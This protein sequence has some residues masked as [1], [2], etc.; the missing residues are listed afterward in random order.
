MIILAVAF[1][2][3]NDDNISTKDLYSMEVQNVPIELQ[4]D[5]PSTP[6]IQ[7]EPLGQSTIHSAI[8][9]SQATQPAPE[10]APLPPPFVPA[11]TPSQQQ[12][13]TTQPPLRLSRRKYLLFGLVIV[14]LFVIGFGG[15][16]VYSRFFKYKQIPTLDQRRFYQAT[17]SALDP[18]VHSDMQAIDAVK[19]AYPDLKDFGNTNNRLSPRTFIWSLQ[20]KTGWKVRFNRGYGKCNNDTCERDQWY[21]FTVD[22]DGKVTKVGE[23]EII[24]KPDG[25]EQINGIRVPN[26]LKEDTLSP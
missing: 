7:A 10:A 26:F 2:I 13:Q 5:A 25:S 14:I 18:S 17:F 24:Q 21:Y 3:G 23:V 20:T 11:P 1:Y 6:S 19:K 12:P 16:W 22:L 4:P 15:A 9:L 8:S